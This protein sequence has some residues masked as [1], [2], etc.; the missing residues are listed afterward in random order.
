MSDLR[1]QAIEQ[2]WVFWTSD[3]GECVSLTA[4]EAHADDIAKAVNSLW[5]ERAIHPLQYSYTQDDVR[6]LVAVLR[7][8]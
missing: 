1:Q 6:S 3:R 2:G 4:L 8:E 7:D 5:R